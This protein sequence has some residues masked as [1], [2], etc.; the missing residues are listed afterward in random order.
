L[1]SDLNIIHYGNS[2]SIYPD[3]NNAAYC[4]V[5]GQQFYKVCG[6]YHYATNTLLTSD[7]RLKEN[8]RE[9][10]QPLEKILRLTGKKYDYIPDD[11]DQNGSDREKQ[12]KTERKKDQLGFVAQEVIGVIPEAVYYEE[13]ADLYYINY[14]AIIPVIVEA[15]KELTAE[16][17]ELK[18]G[19]SMKSAS[20]G[21]ETITDETKEASLGQN[22][23]NPFSTTTRIDVYLPTTA[24]KAKLYLYNMQGEQIKSFNITE[25][26][27]TSV[28]IEGY[29][30]KAGMYL[31]ALIADGKEV[32]T[33][34]M[35]LTK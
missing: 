3:E 4:G 25:R 13:E 8:F 10:D 14:D 24:S 29:S 26:G 12:A 35:I 16:M 7:L 31:Y 5:P 22:V 9:I 11:S 27:N 1:V 15:L 30:L 18:N 6:Q 34:K 19:G 33:K 32:D 20:L 23:P 2:S 17:D 21:T 28:T